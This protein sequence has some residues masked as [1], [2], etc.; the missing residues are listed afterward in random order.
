LYALIRASPKDPVR[1]GIA[2]ACAAAA[3]LMRPTNS[4]SVLLFF[5]YVSLF[6]RKSVIPFVVG[7]VA[8]AAPWVAL[9]LHIYASLLPPYYMPGSLFAPDSHLTEALLG[10]LI[11]PSRGLFTFTP[12]ML[13]ALPG[14]WIQLRA[15]PLKALWATVGLIVVLHWIAISSVPIWWAGHS[16]GPRYFSDMTP[17]L[18]V[19]LVPIVA[20]LKWPMRRSWVTASFLLM[21]GL[22]VVIHMRGA[23]SW[24]VYRWNGEPTNA[25][26]ARV[27]DWKDPQFLR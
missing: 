15:G 22:S 11:S 10:N 26:P 14:L 20:K 4:I 19:L 17:Y 2:G 7:S 24:A 9:N 25:S 16:Y 23:L 6:R 27:W 18:I 1:M 21:A 3:Y 5:L 12:V 13:F 8:I